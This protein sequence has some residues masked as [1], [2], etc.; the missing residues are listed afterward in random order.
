MD[1]Q[2][3]ILEFIRE[4]GRVTTPFIMQSFLFLGLDAIEIEQNLLILET[5]GFVKRTKTGEFEALESKTSS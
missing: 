3:P 4:Y 1:C 2:E 5:Q